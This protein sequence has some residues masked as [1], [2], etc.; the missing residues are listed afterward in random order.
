MT[1]SHRL[2]QRVREDL[3][4][5]SL[6]GGAEPDYWTLNDFRR[7]QR[8]A[9]NDMFTQVVEVAQSLGMGK[10]GHVAI[11]TTR[12]AANAS[13]HRV[14]SVKKLREERAKIRRQIRHWQ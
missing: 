8:R 10:L 2:E 3:A 4:F 5:R 11:D 12:V 6:A 9:L 7:R 13:Q 1:S 14:D